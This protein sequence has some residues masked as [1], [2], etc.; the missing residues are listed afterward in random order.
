MLFCFCC[1]GYISTKILVKFW[2][3]TST[4][5]VTE[6]DSENETFLSLNSTDEER[7]W[8]T[9]FSDIASFMLK[10]SSKYFSSSRLKKQTLY[11]GSRLVRS[12]LMLSL[13]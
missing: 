3:N 2:T 12:Q 11:S 4:E 5:N 7:Q 10:V 1:I 13:G 9:N 8:Q 6:T